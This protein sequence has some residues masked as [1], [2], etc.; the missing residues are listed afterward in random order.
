MWPFRNACWFW[1]FIGWV[2]SWTGLLSTVV[3]V[4]VQI[5]SSFHVMK[6][7]VWRTVNNCYA[8]FSYNVW[9]Q[10]WG[11]YLDNFDTDVGLDTKRNYNQS[12]MK[13]NLI[14]KGLIPLLYFFFLLATKKPHFHLPFGHWLLCW[15]F[16]SYLLGTLNGKNR[17]FMVAIWHSF[18]Y[19]VYLKC[20]TFKLWLVHFWIPKYP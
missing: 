2:T 12:H 1:L 16:S 14:G 17:S 9:K 7:L 10:F 8:N 20:W 15:S 4:H 6:F 3:L 19:V 5:Y 11:Q 13:T 18:T